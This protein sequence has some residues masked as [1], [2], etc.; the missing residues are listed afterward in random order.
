M[1]TVTALLCATDS[2][3]AL[4]RLAGTPLVVHAARMLA[5]CGSL[6]RILVAGDPAVCVA[7]AADLP[8]MT[9]I[10]VADGPLAALRIV[11]SDT[12]TGANT[13]TDVVVIHEAARALAPVELLRATIATVRAGAEV[14]VPVTVVSDTI[15][16][17]ADDGTI[18]STVDR[19]TLRAVQAP[20][21]FD[22]KAVNRLLANG[23][24]SEVP[25]QL[26]ASLTTVPGHPDAFAIDGPAARRL[27]GRVLARR[28]DR[29]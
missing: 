13:G 14:A 29:A 6:E 26:A 19:N 10:P 9:V 1:S 3:V 17:I 8:D 22:R 11:A 23:S 18:L 5:G 2:R 21:C 16:R 25:W 7:V 20:Y 27:A 24:D 12:N 15:K 28:S 4:W